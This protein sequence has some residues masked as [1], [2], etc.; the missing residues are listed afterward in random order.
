MVVL[1]SNME[2]AVVE[3]LSQEWAAIALLFPLANHPT[4]ASGLRGVT[5]NPEA[6]AIPKIASEPALQFG[7]GPN[8]FALGHVSMMAVATVNANCQRT[9]SGSDNSVVYPVASAI[10]A[11]CPPFIGV[12]FTRLKI[13]SRGCALTGVR[14]IEFKETKADTKQPK[15][16]ERA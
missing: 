7:R 12:Q 14:N 2:Y 8:F 6:E 4:S 10:H 5:F 9:G 11:S 16:V 1:N 13:V 3:P 15:Q